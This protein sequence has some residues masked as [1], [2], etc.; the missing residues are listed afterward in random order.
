[1]VYSHDMTNHKLLS[2]QQV[3]RHRPFSG[4][5]FYL[6]YVSPAYSIKDY[7]IEQSYHSATVLY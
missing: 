6:K 5:N 7:S 3:V 1:M 4:S 2:A